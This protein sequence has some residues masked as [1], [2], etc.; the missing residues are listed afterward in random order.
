MANLFDGLVR[1]LSF[2]LVH[3]DFPYRVAR[4]Q[5]AQQIEAMEKTCQSE[6]DL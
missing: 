4:V 6:Q 2:G 5:M 1:V 3:T